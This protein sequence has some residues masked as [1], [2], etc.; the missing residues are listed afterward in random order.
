MIYLS[1]IQKNFNETSV[2]KSVT[3][4]IEAGTIVGLIGP[5][6]CGKSTL[7]KIIAG[8]LKP[9][10]GNMN[11]EGAAAEEVSLMF[12]EGALF[13][14][15]NVLNNVAF[16]LLHGSKPVEKLPPKKKSEVAQKVMQILDEVG[17][18]DAVLKTPEQLSGGMRRRV[19]LARALVNHPR[20]A[21]LDDPTCGLD[22]VASS[23]IMKLILQLHQ[24]LSP[25]TVIVS[26]DLRRLLPVVDQVIAVFNG[27]VAF[28]G[29]PEELGK[30]A[31]QEVKDFVACRYE[32]EEPSVGCGDS[33]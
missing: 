4:T 22:P 5:S 25:T 24:E 2:L 11:L 8:T 12:Q 28:N 19:S 6:G 26:H 10:S 20:L 9:D 1:N 33:K 13:D 7:L 32:I 18:A 29:T 21:L 23:V 14:S 17:L 16:P 3:C 15:M 27:Q 31:P 30:K